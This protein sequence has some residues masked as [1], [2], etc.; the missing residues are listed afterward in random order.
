MGVHKKSR[1]VVAGAKFPNEG[2]CAGSQ[3][4]G[5]AS[6]APSDRNRVTDIWREV[7]G[8]EKDVERLI[9]AINTPSADKITTASNFNIVVKS[10]PPDYFPLSAHHLSSSF[11]MGTKAHQNEQANF[12]DNIRKG[13][14][15]LAKHVKNASDDVCPTLLVRLSATASIPKCTEWANEYFRTYPN[16]PVGLVIL[17][18][19]VVVTDLAKGVSP[20]THYVIPVFSPKFQEWTANAGG[21]AR[22][23]PNMS[24]LV[25]VTVGKPTKMVLTDGKTQT[26]MDDWYT[27]QKADIYRFYRKDEKDLTCELSNPAPG[28]MIHADIEIAGQSGIIEMIAPN[29]FDLLLLP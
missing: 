21:V 3:I 17:Y 14:A 7:S 25:G 18:Q 19:A 10:M 15:N 28:R 20:M 22:K 16:E 29:Q 1:N 9:A 26:E 12:M 11:F 13:C 5:M 2:R 27:Y 6:S 23:L 4:P 8:I 24:V